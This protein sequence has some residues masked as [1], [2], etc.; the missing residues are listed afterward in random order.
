[1][2]PHIPLYFVD[3]WSLLRN[4]DTGQLRDEPSGDW[5]D[6]KSPNDLIAQ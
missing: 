1:M 6:L 2:V 3:S 4:P 5:G